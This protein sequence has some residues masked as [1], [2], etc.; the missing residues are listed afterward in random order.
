MRLREIIKS[1]DKEKESK[2]IAQGRIALQQ[3]D[4]L[5]LVWDLDNDKIDLDVVQSY[6]QMIQK[7]LPNQTVVSVPNAVQ[8]LSVNTV[9]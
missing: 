8:F 1:F 5:I 9:N 3:D 2:P 6:T 7:V 4:V